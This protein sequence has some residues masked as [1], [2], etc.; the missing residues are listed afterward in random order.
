ME[1]YKMIVGSVLLLWKLVWSATIIFRYLYF[2][3]VLMFVDDF[4]QF[5]T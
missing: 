4:A 2:I 1:C 3:C 5:M